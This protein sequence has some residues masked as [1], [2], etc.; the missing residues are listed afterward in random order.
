MSKKQSIQKLIEDNFRVDDQ[1]DE[2][3]EDNIV[4]NGMRVLYIS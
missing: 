2:E 1:F 3:T 4:F